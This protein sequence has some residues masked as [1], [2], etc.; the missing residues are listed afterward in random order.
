VVRNS[1]EETLERRGS[2]RRHSPSL[3]LRS[4]SPYTEDRGFAD[5]VHGEDRSMR[6][7]SVNLRP[8]GL[9]KERPMLNAPGAG[10]VDVD[11]RP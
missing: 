7:A 1:P 2:Q 11:G 9:P 3:A 8:G 6:T 10:R 4:V 5:H